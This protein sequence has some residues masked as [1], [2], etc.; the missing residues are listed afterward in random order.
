M[1]AQSSPAAPSSSAHQARDARPVALITGASRGIGAAIAEELGQDHHILVGGTNPATVDAVVQTLP[2][3]EPFLVDLSDL[4]AIA[5]AFAALGLSGLDVLVHSA[6]LAWM[7]PVAE[8]SPSQF[9][10]MFTVNVF[11]VAELTRA[12][13]P[14]L[15]GSSGQV[16]SIN[17]GAGFTAGAGSSMYSGTKFALR[18][19]TD[20]L[21]EEERGAVKVTS[22]HPGRVD[23]DMQVAL[24][25]SMGNQNYD[26]GIYISPRA[27]AEA[28]R[29]VVDMEDASMVESISIR[30]VQ[31]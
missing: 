5:P 3:A 8:T 1:T 24:Q 16:L 17:S 26:G 9:Q 10:E 4:D 12:A 13:L 28:A 20:A 2:S 15:R 11:A 23:T 21:R 22:I 30:P 31:K 29:T 6:G 18:A 25:E 19:M 27:I 7:N 14:L